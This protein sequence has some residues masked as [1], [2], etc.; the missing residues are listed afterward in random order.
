VGG[1]DTLARPGGM[2]MADP[3]GYLA[4]GAVVMPV[5]GD[6]AADARA[7]A[8]MRRL[9]PDRTVVPVPEPCTRDCRV[10][11]H[12]AARHRHSLAAIK[13]SICC[14]LGLARGWRSCSC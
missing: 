9:F 12:V 6:A 13:I 10:R 4:N 5:F 1:G 8:D 14:G 11:Q 3:A 7:E 2:L